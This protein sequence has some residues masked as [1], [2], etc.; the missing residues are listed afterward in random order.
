MGVCHFESE[1]VGLSEYGLVADLTL[2]VSR[3][4]R[5]GIFGALLKK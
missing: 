2:R 1:D 3:A 4:L 5:G